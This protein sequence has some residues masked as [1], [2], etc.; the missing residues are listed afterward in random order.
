VAGPTWSALLEQMES[1]RIGTPASY[2]DLL[3]RLVAGGSVEETPGTSTVLL[4]A[5]G[6]SIAEAAERAGVQARAQLQRQATTIDA[7]A[8]GRLPTAEAL[9]DLHVPEA[10]SVGAAIDAVAELW[11]QHDAESLRAAQRGA[12][13]RVPPVALPIWIDPERQ[14]AAE[15]PWRAIRDSMERDLGASLEW[16]FISA[17][18]QRIAR[19][20]W[21]LAH[22]GD[23]PEDLGETQ[24]F[25]AL[26]A[27]LIGGALE[28]SSD[29]EGRS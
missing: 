28:L 8:E 12:A 24:R 17:A 21:L 27:W 5:L 10:T 11:G 2:A 16:S 25:S 3:S 29:R 18:E 7:V 13:S 26:V 4:T 9:R 19:W 23:W 20:R 15:H 1:E 22:R 6:A 14:L